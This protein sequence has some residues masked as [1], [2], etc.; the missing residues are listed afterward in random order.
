[1]A[2]RQNIQCHT[3]PYLCQVG[4]GRGKDTNKVK[5]NPTEHQSLVPGQEERPGNRTGLNKGFLFLIFL[6]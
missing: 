6:F 5:E 1:M 2:L 3:F 4:I